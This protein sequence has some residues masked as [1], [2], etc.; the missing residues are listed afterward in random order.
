MVAGE[1]DPHVLADLAHVNMVNKVPEL[2]EALT[3][4]FSE[5]H[6]FM[7]NLH[8]HRIAEVAASIATLDARIDE[9]IKPFQAARDALATI[10]G[11]SKRGR[12]ISSPRSAPT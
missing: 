10:P 4:R 5:H 7:V 11:L 9:V 2:I 8:L 3:G 1:R 6:A 12:R